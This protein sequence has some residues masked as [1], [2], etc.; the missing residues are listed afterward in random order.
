MARLQAF[1]PFW[2]FQSFYSD[3]I[4]ITIASYLKERKKPILPTSGVS[5]P[6]DLISHRFV[7]NP[8]YCMNQWWCGPQVQQTKGCPW[9]GWPWTHPALRLRAC[10]MLTHMWMPPATPARA[11]RGDG[12]P[13]GSNIVFFLFSFLTLLL[14]K[15]SPHLM[16]SEQGRCSGL[17]VLQL[18]E[19]LAP[20][21]SG[22]SLRARIIPA[23]HLLP[24]LS[25]QGARLGAGP[26]CGGRGG[27]TFPI[28]SRFPLPPIISLA[29]PFHSHCPSGSLLRLPPRRQA[30][31]GGV[32]NGGEWS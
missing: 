20:S 7:S 3:H 27:G 32:D 16:M 17:M 24:C 6:R 26:P 1:F 28:A 21:A 18:P 15:A 8:T 13:W 25:C 11:L 9:T 30:S 31:H 12:L 22:W 14:I 23:G 2:I 19:L 10:C 29:S 5:F 4:L